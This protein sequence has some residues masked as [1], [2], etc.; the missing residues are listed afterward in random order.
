MPTRDVTA[1]FPPGPKSHFLVGNLP[2]FMR[3]RLAFLT[4]G[5][6]DY[7][8]VV[9]F[10]LGN[11]S[12]CLLNHPDYIEQGILSPQDFQKS[13]LLRAFR[14]LFGKG[15]LTSEGVKLVKPPV[16]SAAIFF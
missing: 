16:D 7:G 8:D 12:V 9:Y 2:E 14:S 11:A 4:K 5:A 3:H 6:R 1:N 15:L 10:W 13:R